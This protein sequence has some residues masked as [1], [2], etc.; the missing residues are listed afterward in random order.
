MKKDMTSTQKGQKTIE[1]FSLSR[2]FTYVAVMSKK[3]EINYVL[4]YRKKNFY[5]WAFRKFLNQDPGILGIFQ[6][7]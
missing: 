1:I 7:L 4:K 3:N 5:I 2:Q 6:N